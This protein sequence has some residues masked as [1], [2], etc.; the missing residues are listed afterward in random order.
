MDQLTQD[1]IEIGRR[2]YQKSMCASN[3]GNISIRLGSNRFLTTCTGVSKGFLT[4]EHILVMDEQAQLVEGDNKPTSES[5]MHI[6]IYNKRP[7]V[8]AVVH[9]HPIMATA[10]ATAGISLE[11]C[12]LP[13]VAA[14]IGTI[15]L[16]DYATPT[17]EEVPAAIDRAVE[18]T[19]AFLLANHGVVTMGKDVYDA[20]YKMERVEH[21]AHILFVARMLGGEKVLSQPQARKL[22]DL[23]GIPGPAGNATVCQ[24]G[25]ESEGPK[26]VTCDKAKGA[27]DLK[28]TEPPKRTEGVE[29]EVQRVLRML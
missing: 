11:S 7:D 25:P 29:E 23:F 26:A 22:L 5:A 6:H 8:Q 27:T 20:Y 9:A 18:H 28:T 12:V 19:D 13:E 2:L 17:T 4:P 24:P 21:Y 10:F 15:P 3:D 1:I 14:T 16:T